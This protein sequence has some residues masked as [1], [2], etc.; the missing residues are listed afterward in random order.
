MKHLYQRICKSFSQTSR[1]EKLLSKRYKDES[2]RKEFMLNKNKLY[3]GMT[4]MN[5]DLVTK[6][7]DTTFYPMQ[8]PKLLNNEDTYIISY[9]PPV[10]NLTPLFEIPSEIE[11]Y[12]HHPFDSPHDSR[13][14]D[15]GIIGPPN[16]GKSSLIN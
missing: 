3:D 1:L 5:T 13:G 16:S 15:I 6:K 14:L 4:T 9:K 10:K 11:Q 7:K 2:I 8:H 12:Q